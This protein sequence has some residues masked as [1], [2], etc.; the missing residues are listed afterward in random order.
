MDDADGIV[1]AVI[2]KA[3]EGDTG[4]AAIILCRLVPALKAQSEK[5]EFELK[6]SAPSSEQVEAV[7]TAISTGRLAPDVGKQLIDSICALSQV[8]AAEEL[9]TRIAA[10]EEK[11]L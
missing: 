10:L 8:R 3:L 6:S 2:A 5:V 7:L 4:A 11:N 1:D 9:E